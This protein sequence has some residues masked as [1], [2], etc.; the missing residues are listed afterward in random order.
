M[1]MNWN[2]YKYNTFSIIVI[3]IQFNIMIYTN[4]I[5]IY[6][7]SR[8]LLENYKKDRYHY[9]ISSWYYILS[10]YLR[11]SKNIIIHKNLPFLKRK[12]PIFQIS[13][14]QD[15]YKTNSR[16][17]KWLFISILLQN[18]LTLTD[19]WNGKKKEKKTEVPRSRNNGGDSLRVSFKD[20]KHGRYDR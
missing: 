17:K 18:V 1:I 20:E 6:Q 7:I 9:L 16:R 11:K 2:I 8:E 3:L 5:Y 14:R 19:K 4:N 10:N 15:L 13:F 12:Y